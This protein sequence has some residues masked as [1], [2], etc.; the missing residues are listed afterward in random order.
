MCN[1]NFRSETKNKECV[2]CIFSGNKE[3]RKKL[4]VRIKRADDIYTPTF[5]WFREYHDKV[6]E[7]KNK[8]QKETKNNIVSKYT[9]YYT[10]QLTFICKC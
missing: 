9:K 7:V 6:K 1:R 2:R 3:I 5:Q 10:K 4:K 8:C